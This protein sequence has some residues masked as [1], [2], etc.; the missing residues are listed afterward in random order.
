LS[1]LKIEAVNTPEIGI[2]AL[3]KR[4][5]SMGPAARQLWAALCGLSQDAN[6]ERA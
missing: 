1:R 5:R 4:S 3:R 2:F 6:I